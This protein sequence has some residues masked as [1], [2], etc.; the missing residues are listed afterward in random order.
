MC[1]VQLERLS[2]VNSW[3]TSKRMHEATLLPCL[4][5][6]QDA[7]D[8]MTHYVHCPFWLYLLTRLLQQSPPSPL[9]L[10]RIGLVDPTIDSL[11]AVAC[12]FAGYHAVKRQAL[13]LNFTHSHLDP[14]QVA[15]CHRVFLDAFCVA[16]LDCALPCTAFSAVVASVAE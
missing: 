6:C 2:W 1:K 11:L 9:P 10:T 13:E 4:F 5:G 8:C 12:S 3:A 14:T 15:R 16:A 7:I